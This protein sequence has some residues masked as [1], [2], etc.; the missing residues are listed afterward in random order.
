MIYKELKNSKQISDYN[1]CV[2]DIMCN[3]LTVQDYEERYVTKPH[4][5]AKCELYAR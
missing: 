1:E 5:D 4:P 2:A 3:L